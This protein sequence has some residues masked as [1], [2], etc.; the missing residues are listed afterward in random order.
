M[1]KATL[2]IRLFEEIETVLHVAKYSPRNNDVRHLLSHLES[3]FYVSN[4]VEHTYVQKQKD[5]VNAVEHPSVQREEETLAN[6]QKLMLN[7]QLLERAETNPRF[8]CRDKCVKKGEENRKHA[9]HK[10]RSQEVE[11]TFLDKNILLVSFHLVFVLQFFPRELC[12]NALSVKVFSPTTRSV[13]YRFVSFRRLEQCA[14]RGILFDGRQT[15]LKFLI[16]LFMFE[17]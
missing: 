11:E 16:L 14:V 7:L 1:S 10:R 4:P 5:P 2:T 9:N 12:G 17:F 13:E 6:G 8:M 15:T 3:V